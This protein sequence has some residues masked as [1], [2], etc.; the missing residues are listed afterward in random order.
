MSCKFHRISDEISEKIGKSAQ[1]YLQSNN[2]NP[3]DIKEIS[4]I[5]MTGT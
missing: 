1:L 2:N 3:L 4:E 5:L